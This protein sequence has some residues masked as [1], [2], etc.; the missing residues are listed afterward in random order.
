MIIEIIDVRRD[1]TPQSVYIAWDMNEDA[2]PDYMPTAIELLEM[3]Y[4][5][6]YICDYTRPDGGTIDVAVMVDGQKHWVEWERWLID[7]MDESLAAVLIRHALQENL[8]K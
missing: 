8:I 6:E 2:M 1:I 7:E 4:Q 3:L 5:L